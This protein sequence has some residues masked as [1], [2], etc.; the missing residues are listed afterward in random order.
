MS[1]RQAS[2]H[3]LLS[4]LSNELSASVRRLRIQRTP[5]EWSSRVS[6]PSSLADRKAVF[7]TVACLAIGVFVGTWFLAENLSEQRAQRE[8]LS[9]VSHASIVV[10]NSQPIPESAVALAALRGIRHVSAHHSSPTSPIHVEL[11]NGQTSAAVTIARDSDRPNEFWVYLPGS[12][13]HNNALG[14][15]AGRVVSEP[16]GTLLHDRGL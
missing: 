1:R 12:N 5:E 9:A 7:L 6:V 4:E 15:D 8:L 2:R 11:R 14:R 13:W 16:L 10:V 3:R